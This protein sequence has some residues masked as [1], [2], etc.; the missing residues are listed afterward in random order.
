MK[1]LSIIA[2][3]LFLSPVLTTTAAAAQ[4]VDLGQDG[5]VLPAYVGSGNRPVYVT[6]SRVDAASAG[7]V[8]VLR[9]GQASA[10]HIGYDYSRVAGEGVSVDVAGDVSVS[11]SLRLGK[12]ATS[13]IA[14]LPVGATDKAINLHANGNLLVSGGEVVVTAG[15]DVQHAGM[16][17]AGDAVFDKGVM[18]LR[19]AGENGMAVL[20]ANAVDLTGSALTLEAY[21]RLTANSSADPAWMDRY[22]VRINR[23][24]S[25][26]LNS[27]YY[28][29]YN[30]PAVLP[31]FAGV[32]VSAASRG[33]VVREGGVLSA[34]AAGGI[35]KGGVDAGGM[36]FQRLDVDVGGAIDASK[37]NL[38]LTGFGSVN[39]WGSYR[40]G[41]DWLGGSTLRMT[42]VDSVVTLRGNANVGMSVDLQK[43]LSSGHGFGTAASDVLRARDIVFESGRIPELRTGLGVFT[44]ALGRDQA[45]G[46]TALYVAGVANGVRGDGSA[47]DRGQFFHN[48]SGT[49]YSS[50]IRGDLA[51][52]IYNTVVLDAPSIMPRGDVGY[53]N[54]DVFASLASG[55]DQPIANRTGIVDDGVLELYNG[56]AQ[57]GASLVAYNAADSL[58]NSI[59]QRLNLIRS[60]MYAA[61][62][63]SGGALA[64]ASAFESRRKRV[65]GGG[66]GRKEEADA[67]SGVAGYKYDPRGFS[68]GYDRELGE[69]FALGGA[70]AYG[71]GD[72]KDKAA[73][74]NDS[75][76]ESYSASI[77]GAFR[78][79]SGFSMTAFAAYSHLDNDLSDQR[80]GM[81]RRA[82]FDSQAWA[83]GAKIG[84]D[85]C[86]ADRL[87]VTPS[88]GVTRIEATNKAHD[89]KLDGMDVIRVGSAKRRST[90]L[91]IEVA[92]GYD[93]FRGES[94]LLRFTG[95]F[96]YAYD[97]DDS[98]LSGDLFYDGLE[99]ATAVSLSGRDTGRHRFNVG[100]GLLY[101]GSRLDLEAKYEYYRRSKQEAHQV[102]GAVGVKF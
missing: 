65:W 62:V 29:P 22:A 77:Y 63:S 3:L 21:S 25:L 41:F 31:V 97:F 34:G 26:H 51:E 79:Y 101:S 94:S 48:L 76:I 56:A 57:D 102:K 15:T 1:K 80:G 8:D 95:T 87:L 2:W 81:A 14:G 90:L 60:E 44:L 100:A 98:G 86:P 46:Y 13:G 32:D 43:S 10:M 30:P 5:A 11:G 68:L 55:V 73:V 91:P 72:Y 24:G 58:V 17:V 4:I 84:Y 16:S 47:G 69:R 78:G 85:L 70:V 38:L 6:N 45:A 37:G 33:I 64:S 96:G 12:A 83:A 50:T 53:F 19:G 42:A 71:K 66:F 52:N 49:S 23:G 93:L 88:V 7:A 61:G 36:L 9:I 74:A 59:G 92:M 54:R 18:A 99:G 67:K 89:E 28:D 35:V 75:E 40:A 20:S 82:D 39:L 27:G